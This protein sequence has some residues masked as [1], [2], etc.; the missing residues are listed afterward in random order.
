ML[1]QVQVSVDASQ[2]LR[3]IEL[4]QRSLT[5]RTLPKLLKDTA[6]GVALKAYRL[7]APMSQGH[8]AHAL[9][10]DVTSYTNARRNRPAMSGKGPNV[11]TDQPLADNAHQYRASAYMGQGRKFPRTTKFTTVRAAPFFQPSEQ[12]P[13]PLG[14]LVVMARTRADS[15]YSKL[16]DNRWPLK[17]SDLPTGTG[18]SIARQQIIGAWIARMVKGRK[19]SAGFLR[20]AWAECANR[21]KRL[22]I[23]EGGRSVIDVGQV[24]IPAH[25]HGKAMSQVSSGGS[26][27][28]AQWV[29]IENAIGE[30]GPN[31]Q[32]RRQ[33]YLMKHG[34]PALEAALMA[35]TAEMRAHYLPRVAGTELQRAWQSI[36]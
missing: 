9:D 1:P 10:V 6:L 36:R 8:P 16:T 13:V 26:G 23:G 4:A 19:S 25:R 33:L 3:A 29:R 35:Q 17:L 7:T 11:A 12:R 18:S 28:P 20:K 34:G 24:G 32:R 2:V 22:P 5:R 31:L 15:N 21:V 27:T 14:V 30:G